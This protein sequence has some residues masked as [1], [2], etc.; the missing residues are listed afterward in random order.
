MT[1]QDEFCPALTT[2]FL[3]FRLNAIS[4]SR[5]DVKEIENTNELIRQYYPK[6]CSFKDATHKELLRIQSLDSVRVT[7]LFAN[8][9]CVL[10][11][12]MSARSKND[13][14]LGAT[15]PPAFC[16]Q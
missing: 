16:A 11:T 3:I 13:L 12:L 9:F 10:R 5:D 8:M 7:C 15:G 2:V 14:D 6:G 4:V 1:Y